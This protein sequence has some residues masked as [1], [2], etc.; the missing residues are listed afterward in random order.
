MMTMGASPK[1]S[2]SNGLI[3]GG[4]MMADKAGKNKSLCPSLSLKTRV[5]GWLICMII[6]F[7]VSFLSAGMLRSV[8]KGSITKFVILY[9]IGT[10]CALSS[11][12][13][14]WGPVS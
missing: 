14:L 4:L 10:V 7:V 1:E 8:L 2:E 5:K 9:S 11:S 3:D 12:L 13:F 6:G